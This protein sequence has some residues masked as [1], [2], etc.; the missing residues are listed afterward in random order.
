MYKS[1]DY[2][3]SIPEPGHVFL[4]LAVVV[5]VQWYFSVVLI[6]AFLIANNMDYLYFFFNWPFEYLL[7]L[8]KKPGMPSKTEFTPRAAPGC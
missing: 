2:F 4:V 7:L 6:F 5:S 3:T 1:C 8:R